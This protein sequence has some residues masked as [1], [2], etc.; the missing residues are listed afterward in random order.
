MAV[1][2]EMKGQIILPRGANPTGLESDRVQ[3]QAF[4]AYMCCVCNQEGQDRLNSFISALLDYYRGL[5]LSSSH[6]KCP[7]DSIRSHLPRHRL[8]HLGHER[9]TLF[10]GPWQ[11]SD[12]AS[13]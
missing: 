3:G 9:L 1:L 2:Y 5:F 10:V 11:L 13:A 4:K 12:L 8:A 6:C 7:P